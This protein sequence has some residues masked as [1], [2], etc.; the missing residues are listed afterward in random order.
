MKA[1]RHI[2]KARVIRS[3]ADDNTRSQQRSRNQ[4]LPNIA[5]SSDKKHTTQTRALRA[6]SYG[7][8]FLPS[9]VIY[10]QLLPA[11]YL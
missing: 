10:H 7:T 2:G 5:S 6:Q 4:R 3:G 1:T 11:P 9:Q 8:K